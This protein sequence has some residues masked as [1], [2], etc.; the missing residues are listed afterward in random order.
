MEPEDFEPQKKKPPLKNLEIMGIEELRDYIDGMKTE[1]ARAE[2]M[3]KSKQ[4]ARGAA[5][6]FFKKPG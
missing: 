6:L 2:A 1:I 5:D 3:I 4:S